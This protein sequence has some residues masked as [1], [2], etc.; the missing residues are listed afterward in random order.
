MAAAAEYVDDCVSG[1]LVEPGD[2]SGF[3]AAVCTL[4]WQHQHLPEL[5]R[6]AREAALRARWD[7]ALLRFEA[8][9]ADT[10]SSVATASAEVA[11][12]A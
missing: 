4:A 8:H 6:Y 1:L 3:V 5:R 2:E 7:D 10:L 11:C 9:L 12:A